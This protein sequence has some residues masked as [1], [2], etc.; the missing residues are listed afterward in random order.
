V[1]LLPTLYFSFAFIVSPL[2][3]FV[4]I[5]SSCS[6]FHKDLTH[7]KKRTSRLGRISED[8][9]YQI[10]AQSSDSG[11]HKNPTQQ[12]NTYS[13]TRNANRLWAQHFGFGV[14]CSELKELRALQQ[15]TK[16]FLNGVSQITILPNGN[17]RMGTFLNSS[18]I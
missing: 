9:A 4:G 6:G 17:F 5:R 18:Q 11:V 13:R 2:A 12:P 8:H 1:S 3:T 15:T 16:H 10:A 14:R 7:I